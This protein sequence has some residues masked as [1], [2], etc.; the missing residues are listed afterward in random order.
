LQGTLKMFWLLFVMLKLRVLATKSDKF[1]YGC[2][3]ASAKHGC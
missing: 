3:I 1:L 2:S